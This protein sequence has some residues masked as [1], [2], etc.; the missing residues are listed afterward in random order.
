MKSMINKPIHGIECYLKNLLN[1]EKNFKKSSFTSIS[2]MFTSPST[3]TPRSPFIFPIPRDF[4][5]LAQVKITISLKLNSLS[6][7]LL[8]LKFLNDYYPEIN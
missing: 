6:R 7:I 8:N 1:K 2:K 5:G 4:A 3:P